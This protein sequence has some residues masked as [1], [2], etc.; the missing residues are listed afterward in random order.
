VE[1]DLQVGGSYRI[2]M[3]IEG[4]PYTAYGTYKEI[5]PPRRLVYTWDW[6]EESHQVGETTVTV[7]FVEVDGGT[8]V[9]LTHD[10]FP[11]PEAKEAHEQG[12]GGCLDRFEALLS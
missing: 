9:R 8:E 1:L 6:T 5:D 4:G 3:E 12:W 7:E 11:A 2:R 10:G